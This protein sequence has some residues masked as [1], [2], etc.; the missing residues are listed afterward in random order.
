MDYVTNVGP[1][2]VP[3]E[4]GGDRPLLDCISDD[5]ISDDYISDDYI[6]DDYHPSVMTTSVM[7]MSASASPQ[8]GYCDPSLSRANCS[9]T[10]E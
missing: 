6:S 8:V 5:C 3:T 7:H 2:T 4:Q 1:A 10:D 9:P